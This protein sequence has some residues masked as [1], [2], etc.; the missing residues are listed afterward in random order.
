MIEVAAP[1]DSENYYDH[2]QSEVLDLVKVNADRVLEIGCASGGLL[3][4]FRERGASKITGVEYVSEVAE[5]ARDRLPGSD[6]FSGD[7]DQ[8][9]VERIGFGYDLLIA[10]FVLEHVTDP[11]RTLNRVA[12]SL[13]SGG[14]LIGSLPNVRHWSVTAP[15][16]FRGKWEYVDEGILDRTHYRFFT[17]HTIEELL[18]SCGFTDI[19]I[20]PMITAKKSRIGNAMTFG[21]LK[22]HF[23]FA[24][25][26]SAIKA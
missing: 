22:D 4:E 3:A 6:I 12:H 5:R 16:I 20:M 14:Q 19:E 24:Y 8:I 13:K 23:A 21:F 17:K 2:D 25:R 15:L 1:I 9:D 26:F 10:N 18:R 7:I 11:W